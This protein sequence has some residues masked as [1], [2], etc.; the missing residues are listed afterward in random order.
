ML[1]NMK[2]LEIT[3]KQF[4]DKIGEGIKCSTKIKRKTYSCKYFGYSEEQAKENFSNHI[5]IYYL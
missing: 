2:N 5:N 3:V 1:H 4:K